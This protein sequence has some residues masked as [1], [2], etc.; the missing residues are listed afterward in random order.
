MFYKNKGFIIEDVFRV[1]RKSGNTYTKAR[2]FSGLA[3][4]ISGKSV[5]AFGKKN[6]VYANTGSIIYIPEGVDFETYSENEEVIIIH[7]KSFFDTDKKIISIVPQ[8]Y[9][10]F[11]ELFSSIDEEWQ[12]RKAGYKSRCTSL[13]YSIFENLEKNTAELPDKKNEL[14]KNGITYMKRHYDSPDLTVKKIAE[15]CNISEVYF[16]KVYKSQYKVSPLKTI[17]D[18]RIKR[19]CNL[20][21]SGYYNVSQAAAMSG[22]GDV[23]YF[24]TVFK[25]T[26][27]VTPSDYVKIKNK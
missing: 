2:D 12:K 5:F 21:K 8:N 1:S 15:K 26:K 13:L 3:F 16:R 19:A 9:E 14:I 18:L 17:N 24:S 27:G 25:K 20:L 11:A 23:K 4:R 22:F 7:L 10:V 6:K